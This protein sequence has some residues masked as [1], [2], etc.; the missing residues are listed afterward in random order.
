MEQRAMIRFFTLKG[1][2]TC[3][4]TIEPGLTCSGEPLCDD[5][6]SGR[7]LIND[8]AEAIASMLQERFF[9]P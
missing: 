1:V 8:L 4:I 3:D 6:R 9:V 7:L 2:F 5:R